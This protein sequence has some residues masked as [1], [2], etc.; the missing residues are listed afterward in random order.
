[1]VL[2]TLVVIGRLFVLFLGLCL[3]GRIAGLKRRME[4]DLEFDDDD[5]DTTC[6]L[7][8]HSVGS[9]VFLGCVFLD[10]ERDMIDSVRL[11]L[12]PAGACTF[13]VAR[14]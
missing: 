11:G 12:W 13:P 9:G 6:F 5:D 7:A 4:F 2:L 1:M 14:Q 8:L 10:W 3:R